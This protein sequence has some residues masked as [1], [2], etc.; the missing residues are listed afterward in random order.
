MDLNKVTSGYAIPIGIVIIIIAYII[1]FQ[2]F[3]ASALI[4]LITSTVGLLFFFIGILEGIMKH[5]EVIESATASAITSAVGSICITIITPIMLNIINA[6]H[7]FNNYGPSAFD[8]IIFVIVG[9]VGGI[10]GYYLIREIFK[11]KSREHHF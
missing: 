3:F 11:Q 5:D 10:I 1:G 9:I 7:Y 2:L 8:L 6:P 4:N